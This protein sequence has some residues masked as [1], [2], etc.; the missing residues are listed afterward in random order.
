MGG[1]NAVVDSE[2]L[3]HELGSTI[4]RL[5]AE[6]GFSQESFASATGLHR[7]YMGGVERGERNVG[8][9]NLWQIAATLDMS[10]SE[11]FAELERT[12]NEQRRG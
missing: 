2:E 5:R 12:S 1:S 3:L 8:V 11:F 4:R 10:L 7:T 6:R 9:V